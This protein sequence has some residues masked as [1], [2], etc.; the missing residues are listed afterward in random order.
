MDGGLGFAHRRL[1]IIDLSDTALQPMSNEDGSVWLIYNGEVYNY[2]ELR[3]QLEAKGH[4]F[5]SHSDTEVII[6]AYEQWGLD[7]LSRFNGMFA[8]ALWDSEQ[9][10]LLLAR[11]RLGVKPLYYRWN[12]AEL[13]FA[14]EIKALLAHPDIPAVAHLPAIGQYMASM[15]TTGDQTWFEGVKRLLP[16]HYLTVNREGLRVRR[17]WDLPGE[18][19]D[20]GE[21]PERYYVSKARAILDD[22]VRL[23]LRADVPLGSHLSGGVD[24]SAIVALLSRQ[25][26]PAGETLRTFSGAFAEGPRYDERRYI[27]AVVERYH[28]DQHETLPVASDLAALFEQMVW[29][30]DEPAA[31]P[32]ILLQWKVCELTHRSGVTVVNGGQGGDEEW[33]G[34]FGYIPS[35]LKTLL[36]QARRHPRLLSELA[37]E[38]A[39]LVGRSDTRDAFFRALVVGRSGRLRPGTGIGEWAG[40]RF[41]AAP[42]DM[43]SAHV[44]EIMSTA[45][46]TPLG[47]AMYWDTKWYLPALLQVED[48]TSMAFSIESRAPLLDYRLV[49][50]AA[51]T[52]GALKLKGLEMKYVLREAVKDLLPP[53]VYNR[54]DKMGMPTPLAPWLR[55][56]LSRW[57]RGELGGQ[58]LA[59]SRLL[60]PAY[61]HTALAEH[62]G[63]QRDR[64]NDLW[65]M[66]NLVAWWSVFIEGKASWAG[67]RKER[68][69]S[70]NHLLLT[71]SKPTA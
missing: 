71:A 48:R 49:E 35:Y 4:H 45:R 18:E 26:S 62:M 25:L 54:T 52:P 36:L 6:H 22:S 57:V 21:K 24:S 11:D 13:V 60:D 68:Q 66:L 30:M 33:G 67:T 20:L 31:G 14:S 2:L 8:F 16:G 44:G 55:G 3:P 70:D 12:G 17:W 51:Y 61:V 39:L 63:G 15:Y 28:T 38:L 9:R 32:G 59:E 23:R 10:R 34:Y 46:R 5:K 64:S 53:I 56:P 1:R 37:N 19:N 58:R 43:T 7:C 40:E 69:E 42:P 47:A 27:R 29:H 41:K 50:H 65:K